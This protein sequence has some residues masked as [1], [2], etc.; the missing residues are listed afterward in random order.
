MSGS[1]VPIVLNVNGID[2]PVTVDSTRNLFDA[3]TYTEKRPEIATYIQDDF[4]VTRKLTLK[5]T[6]KR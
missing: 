2:H 4:R 3:G 1:I 6:R 5:P